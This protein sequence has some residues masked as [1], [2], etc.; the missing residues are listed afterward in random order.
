MKTKG[1]HFCKTCEDPEPL[2]DNCA[3]QHTRHK[4][5]RDHEICDAIEEIKNYQ[6]SSIYNFDM[7]QVFSTGPKKRKSFLSIVIVF[8]IFMKENE[9]L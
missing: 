1:T 3:R 6:E 9:H 8:L 4:L 5:F 7:G 2:C